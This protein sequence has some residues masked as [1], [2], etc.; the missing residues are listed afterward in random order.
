MSSVTT[1]SV[2]TNAL[3]ACILVGVFMAILDVAIVNVALPVMQKTIHA[4]GAQLQLV[5]ASYIATY[6]TLL[7]TGARL[8]DMFGYR[9]LF[10]IGVAIFTTAS[11][12]CG[13]AP[14]P[15]TLIGFRVVQ[16]A[17][18]AWMIPQVLS[19]IQNYFAGA[20]RARALGIYATV[21]GGAAIAG[22]VIGGVIV[23]ANLFGWQWRPVFLVNV[24]I[25]IVLWVASR[26]YI[27]ADTGQP[28][29]QLDL[30]GVAI[31]SFAV[32]ALVIPLTLGREWRSSTLTWGSLASSFIAMVLFGVLEKRTSQRGGQPL[33]HSRL[34]RAPGFVTGILAILVAMGGY[35]GIL[36][37][38]TLYVQEGLRDRPLIAGLVFLPSAIAFSITS[39]NWRKLPISWHRPMIP[40]G[41]LISSVALAVLA[42]S[43]LAGSITLPM[44]LAIFCFGGGM[45]LAFSPLFNFSLA[46]VQPTD[47]ADASGVLATVNQLGQ[48]IGI[49]VYG[50]LL[51]GSFHVPA[52]A[53]HAAIL[54]ALAMSAG[55]ALAAMVALSLPKP[56]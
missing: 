56:K 16:G 40:I 41:L 34:L 10:L 15:A 18:A 35:G 36:F 32:L 3:L 23:N 33:I 1:R 11:L 24:P 5:V 6:A 46:R 50:T 55:A 53:P 9:R 29:R 14:S 8:G 31:L 20:E 39:L 44:E 12:A 47:A 27:P 4:S 54:T 45:G 21:I 13:L 22:Q 48:V 37:L 7:I 26:L 42:V 43:L 38:L 25:G 2:R 30:Q 19:F 28:G 17:G 52:D 49:A 51:L